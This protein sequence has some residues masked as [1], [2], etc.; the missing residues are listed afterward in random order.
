MSFITTLIK[1]PIYL[2][3]FTSIVLFANTLYWESSFAGHYQATFAGGKLPSPH[4]SGFLKG[5][6]VGWFLTTLVKF[7]PWQGKNFDQAKNN[8]INIIKKDGKLNQEFPFKNWEGVGTRDPTVKVFKID[9]DIP[10]NAFW[11]RT[12]LDELV[13]VGPGD[14]L[15]KMQFV[16]FK[17]VVF[18]VG[19]FQLKKE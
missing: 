4:V 13:Q 18:T 17:G 19:Y 3:I 8:G 14:Y 6:P 16:P 11:L 5:T 10:E 2:V 1:L 12:V 9:Y 15:G 7:V